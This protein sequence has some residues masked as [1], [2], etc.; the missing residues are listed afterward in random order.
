[1]SES[2]AIPGI[3]R[4]GIIRLSAIGDV[5]HAMPLAMT[6]R[7]LY[8]DAHITWVTQ[9]QAAPL[10]HGH[11]A[12]DDVLLFPRHADWAARRAFKEPLRA[13]RFDA[14]VDPQGNIKSGIV[15]R[16]AGARIRAGLAL[17]ECK[18]WPNWFFN[19]RHGP[20]PASAHAVDRAF[21]AGTPLGA[22][23]GPDDW[24]L[25]ASE[26]EIEE[27]RARCREG[28]ADPN[29][30]LTAIS[31]SDPDDARSWF[32]EH[33]IALIGELRARGHTVVLNGLPDVAEL[34]ARLRGPGVFDLTG[35][36]DLRG[37]LA[38][39]QTMAARP[40]SLLVATDSGPV[41]IATAVGLPVVCLSGSQDPARTGPRHGGIA[42]TAW[43]GLPCAPCIERNCEL[44]PPT[45]DCM[46]NLLPAA[47]L[48]AIESIAPQ[49]RAR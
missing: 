16:L 14:T 6:L 39:F 25:T 34:G 33:W 17:R 8:P 32:A 22:G 42:V 18:E 1:M 31:L 13:F 21:A 45:R 2:K 15:A 29:A 23:S 9:E 44:K 4:L 46:R 35:Q 26:G 24:G 38:Q 37:L 19:N 20:R 40:G 28:G 5:V 49:E 36:D 43:E 3:R 7:R 47:V 27:W 41:H 30:P 10:L 12:V 48:R 11:P